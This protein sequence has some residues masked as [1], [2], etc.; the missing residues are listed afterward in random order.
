MIDRHYDD[1][2][3]T[4]GV[5]QIVDGRERI[6]PLRRI[7]PERDGARQDRRTFVAWLQRRPPF[8]GP[9]CPD[10]RAFRPAR[11]QMHEGDAVGA[12]GYGKRDRHSG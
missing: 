9:M 5:P 10:I 3:Q 7:R 12:A 1:M 8:D 6:E 11:D 2:R 4:A